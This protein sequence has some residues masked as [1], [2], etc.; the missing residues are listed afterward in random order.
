MKL[1]KSLQKYGLNEKQAK[2]YLA[3]LALGSASVYRISQRAGLPRSTGYE[4]LNSLKEYGLV[5]T[6]IK[7]KIRYYNAESPKVA[8]ELAREKAEV[9]EKVLPELIA[10]YGR[11]E[12]RP[13]VRFYQGRKNV[14]IALNDMLNAKEIVGFSSAEDLFKIFAKEHLKFLEKRIQKKIPTRLIMHDSETARE[15]KRLGVDEYR[16]IKI[17]PSQY[18]HHGSVLIYGNKMMMFLY[19]QKQLM[20]L[21]VESEGLVQ[22]QRSIFNYLWDNIKE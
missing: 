15:R 2:I 7:K 22:I 19:D 3:C 5:T 11:P 13:V 16:H 18:K 17:I 9:L 10:M 21:V 4:I 1:E 6:F 8:I 12:E 20:T 14:E